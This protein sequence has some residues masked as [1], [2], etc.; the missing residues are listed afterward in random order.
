MKDGVGGVF[1]CSIVLD[2]LIHVRV[3]EFPGVSRNFQETKLKSRTFCPLE[4]SGDSHLRLFIINKF[5]VF[6]F[7]LISDAAVLLDCSVT[8]LHQYIL[9]FP[10]HANSL[11]LSH[12]NKIY[13]KR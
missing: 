4:K 7:I 10:S 13:R 9:F 12:W 11:F 8:E 2:I 5:L 6:Y 1:V 3:K